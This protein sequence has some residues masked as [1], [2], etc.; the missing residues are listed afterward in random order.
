M[1]EDLE[2]ADAAVESHSL[3]LSLAGLIDD[4]LLGWC[5][6]LVAVGDIDYALEL[7]T[8]S[9]QADRI[10]LPAPLHAEL[11]DAAQR[12]RA[13]G[14]GESFPPPDS[15]PRM[16]HRFTHDPAEHG[17]GSRDEA[18]S[19][20][21]ALRGVPARLLRDCQLW[22]T[23]R[24]TPAG[25]APGPLPHPVLLVET[26]DGVGAEVLAYQVAEVLARAGVFAS[27][28]VFSSELELGD[29]HRVA[30]AHSHS[31]FGSEVFGSESGDEAGFAE[32]PVIGGTGPLEAL[33]S[34]SPSSP[35]PSPPPSPAPRV[36][37]DPPAD[38]NGSQPL[39]RVSDNGVPRPAPA[40]GPDGSRRPPP[41]HPVDRVITARS[42]ATRRPR[43]DRQPGSLDDVAS[44]LNFERG[45]GGFP[46]EPETP[47]VDPDAVHDDEQ[48]RPPAPERPQPE[49]RGPERQRNDSLWNGSREPGPPQRDS[50]RPGPPPRPAATPPAAD[51]GPAERGPAERAPGARPSPSPKRP[52]PRPTDGPQDESATDLS[53]VEQRLLRQLHEELASREDRSMPD[54]D[55]PPSRIYRGAN[56]SRKRPPRPGP[57]RA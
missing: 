38:P 21:T 6:E 7:V 52:S 54:A 14:R 42:S 49:R 51:R 22:L 2:D 39:R 41:M 5:R 53:D 26:L 32:R 23:W 34:P 10:R 25:G 35:L 43:P 16:S 29:Y 9:V 1:P 13:L 27:V 11:V 57:E 28:E 50:D 20:E 3:L 40:A 18:Q 47:G 36:R 55:Q 19:P 56:G 37:V 48:P 17:F 12:R 45:V 31:V 8:A 30:L 15:A 44:G 33:P 4:E 24:L 46:V